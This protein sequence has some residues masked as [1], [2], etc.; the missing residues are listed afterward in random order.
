MAIPPASYISSEQEIPRP[1]DVGILA[2][3]V[4]FP[5][6]CISEADL[7]V[8]DGV[9][10][11]KYTIGLG[12]E[13]MACCDDREDI[14]SFALNAVSGLLERYNIDPKS[15]GRI[16]VGTETIIDK[17]KSVKTTL[18]D[19]FSESGNF[20]IEGIDSKNACY[21]STAALFNAVNWVESTSWDGRNAIVVG[22][23]IA[24]YAEGAARPAGGAGAVA[25]LIGPNAPVV[26]EPIHGNHMTNTYDF[27][28]P[29]LDSEYPEVDGPVSVTTY[30][31]ALD[32]SY[33]RF[34]EKTA[35][36]AKKAQLNGHANGNG[37]ANGN[38]VANGKES[39]SFSIENIDYA[40]FH[41]PYGKQVQKGFG[42]LFYNDF[43]ANPSAPQF[44]NIPS[45]ESI[46]ATSYT[47]S[48]TDKNLEKTFIGA[49]KATYAKKV[50]PGMACSKRLGNM[51]T[52]SL[53]GCLASVLSS[54]A[55]SELKGK[56]LSMFAF[57]SGCAASFFTLRVKGDTSE[58]REKMD[59]LARLASMK[60]VPCQEYVDALTLREKNHNAV[61]YT[62]E[63]SIDNIWPGTY[64]LESVDSKFRR[65]YAR[66]PK[67]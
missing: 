7:E 29:R 32:A 9:P 58:I 4:Y 3:E 46:L 12:Q 8:F 16:D 40:I 50:E 26:V 49:S 6:R 59:L 14:N 60:L 67:A 28:K 66:A 11:G 64:Y 39:S 42:R 5:H 53:Y 45:P 30:T 62:P 24:I 57:G 21:G 1:K 18:M 54:V 65:K 20:D 2:M 48:L 47:A 44:A 19:L 43:L 36:A 17:S 10:S 37:Y 27:Y 15:I 52:G 34:R 63:G 31:S 38:G 61:N 25:L 56:R 55:P 35:K 13:Y 51:Y 33:S 23:D 41:S 22:G